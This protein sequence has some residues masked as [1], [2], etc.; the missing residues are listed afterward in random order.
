MREVKNAIYYVLFNEQKHLE[1]STYSKVS[2][3]S[4][5]LCVKEALFLIRKFAKEK[6]VTIEVEK[7]FEWTTD[8]SQSYLFRKGWALICAESASHHHRK[9]T[10]TSL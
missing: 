6:K 3:Y 4:S 7:T 8:L 1:K 10:D 2:E 5:L 9:R